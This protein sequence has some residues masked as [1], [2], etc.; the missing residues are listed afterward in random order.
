MVTSVLAL[1][2][3]LLV[4]CE[5]AINESES[6]P[7]ESITLSAE[8]LEIKFGSVASLAVNFMPENAFNKNVE[9]SSSEEGIVSISD[10]GEVTALK[11]GETT[12]TATTRDGG[13]TASCVVTVIKSDDYIDAEGLEVF[14]LSIMA[15]ESGLLKY[16]FTPEDASNRN[17]HWS[18]KE[19]KPEGCITLDEK[20]GAVEGIEPGTAT[21]LAVSDEGG[22]EDECTVTVNEFVPTPVREIKMDASRSVVNA[23]SFNLDFEVNPSDYT[24]PLKWSIVSTK[25]TGGIIIDENTGLITTIIEY[26]EADIYLTADNSE[27]RELGQYVY[28]VVVK[29]HI[30]VVP[31]YVVDA[32]GTVGIYSPKGLLAFNDM[33]KENPA[34]NG[35]LLDNVDLSQEDV[36]D[37]KPI[38]TSVAPY[39]GTFDGGGFK[40]SNL[41]IN[42][43]H[44]ASTSAT[45]Q[46]FFGH[47][48]AVTS[49]IVAEDMN[50]GLFG[51]LSGATIKNLTVE[52]GYVYGL[53]NVG[54]IAGYVTDG[55]TIFNCTGATDCQ[56][57]LYDV[58]SLAGYVT[59]D[60]KIIAC[61]G[62]AGTV[63]NGNTN[64]LYADAEIKANIKISGGLIG[65]ANGC[66]IVGCS[67]L[68]LVK[69]TAQAGGL[70]CYL[71]GGE[72]TKVYGSYASATMNKAAGVGFAQQCGG[73]VVGS[74]W[75]KTPLC[76]G[77]A[78]Y[79]YG[80]SKGIET[81]TRETLNVDAPIKV[82]N[83]A[84]TEAGYGNNIEFVKGSEY[85]IIKV[86]QDIE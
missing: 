73:T 56:A 19:A 51:Y 48:Y 5:D 59:G 32:D 35:R 3:V 45:A 13:H 12:V 57:Y 65:S 27:A 14:D 24:S 71:L 25:N 46:V 43:N 58:G 39:T 40:I 6:L 33:A 66:T 70:A 4:S 60:S 18:I 55:S 38:G 81:V 83:D 47:S 26:S 15:R 67:T 52:G 63:A 86:L 37:W 85:P 22:F 79:M 28:D 75:A 54:T 50:V 64:E 62:N 17:I 44:Y 11:V 69:T 7:V 80:S 29:C 77:T 41:K 68:G 74:Y 1:C 16:K 36:V 2:A 9:W 42:T 72:T 82:M 84:I 10:E 61:V 23:I 76:K 34:I 8:T 31:D 53:R 30:K 78:P 21:I 20:T 49:L